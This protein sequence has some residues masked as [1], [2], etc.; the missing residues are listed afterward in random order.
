MADVAEMPSGTRLAEEEQRV[1]ARVRR[2]AAWV[3][4]LMIVICNAVFLLGVWSTGFNLDRLIR[5]PDISGC[6]PALDVASGGRIG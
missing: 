3:T 4:A 1:R 6:L 2:Y 5:F